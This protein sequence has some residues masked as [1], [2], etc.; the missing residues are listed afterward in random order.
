MTMT[1]GAG[2]GLMRAFLTVLAVV[3]SYGAAQAGVT[4]P[5]CDPVYWESLKDRAW[6]EAEREIIQNQNLIF[7]ADSVLEYTCFDQLINTTGNN[8][9]FLFSNSTFWGPIR[10]IFSLNTALGN[11]VMNDTRGYLNSNFNHNFLGGRYSGLRTS[12][13]SA[14]SN[15]CQVMRLVWERSKCWNFIEPAFADTDGFY[16]FQELAAQPDPR[17]YPTQCAGPGAGRWNTSHLRALNAAS[18]AVPTTDLGGGYPFRDPLVIYF[19]NLIRP[20]LNPGACGNGVV[21]TGVD[22]RLTPGAGATTFPDGICTNPGCT[23]NG[24]SQ[25]CN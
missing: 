3:L 20:K 6:L 2:K 5:T 4:R 16:T 22:V 19:T 25:T 21:K 14:S 23:Y 13:F 7:K 15:P 18:F 9:G 12:A 17:K 11:V 1:H 24:S 10:S 8:A